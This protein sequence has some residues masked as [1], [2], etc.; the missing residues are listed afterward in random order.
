MI[1]KI[2]VCYLYQLLFR[3]HEAAAQIAQQ[4]GLNIIGKHIGSC[5]TPA[6]S[7]ASITDALN[8]HAVKM[9]ELFGRYPNRW[10][11]IRNEFRS[12]AN[13]IE[14]ESVRRKSIA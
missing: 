9:F 8:K 7:N 11:L 10:T 13:I 3:L 4:K 12:V 5:C 14:K 6:V 1:H 2:K